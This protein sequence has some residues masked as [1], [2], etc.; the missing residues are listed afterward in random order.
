MG[1]YLLVHGG[2]QG[3]WC[4][5]RLVPL[6]ERAGHEVVAPDLPGHGS[7]CTPL[8][9]LSLRGYAERVVAALDALPGPAVLVGHSLGG[10]VISQAAEWRPARVRRLI[11]LAA[12]L[13]GDGQ[14][15]ADLAR[16]DTENL[17]T[18]NSVP[19]GDGAAVAL[20]DE[21]LRRALYAGCA[22][23]D[24]ALAR[25]LLRPEPLRPLGEPVRLTPAR[26]GAVPRCYVE[27]LQDRALPLGR[28]RL[29]HAAQPCQAVRSLP[30]GHSP[31]LSMPETLV[32]CLAG[33]SDPAEP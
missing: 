18:P 31:F 12:F 8:P 16:G 28:Q 19:S 10:M 26:F 15:L 14:S 20:T 23:E 22:A 4:W 33:L 29:M 25:R 3:A 32:E 21:G 7:D 9:S 1:C 30:A 17:L 13:P 5:H 27:C 24:L 6:L 11:Y 2:W